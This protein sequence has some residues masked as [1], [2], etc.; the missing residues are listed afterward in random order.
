MIKCMSYL[1]GH[2]EASLDKLLATAS[3][4]AHFYSHIFCDILSKQVLSRAQL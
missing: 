2:F 4:N 3:L 1:G